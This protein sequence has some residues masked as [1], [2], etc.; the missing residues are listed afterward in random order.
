MTFIKAALSDKFSSD[1][2]LRLPTS[3]F[4]VGREDEAVGNTC[5][6]KSGGWIR[7]EKEGEGNDALKLKIPQSLQKEERDRER[8][9][10][11]KRNW[12]RLYERLLK[13]P[14]CSLQSL[15]YLKKQVLS[16]LLC[17]PVSLPDSYFCIIW[18]PAFSCISPRSGWD[19]LFCLNHCL[20]SVPSGA[21]FNPFLP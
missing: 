19:F 20:S 13:P 5:L 11:K 17:V 14:H 1:V 4:L 2:L 16:L 21:F 18:S 10:G 8:E 9:R 15:K 7:E 3:A 12:L 6:E